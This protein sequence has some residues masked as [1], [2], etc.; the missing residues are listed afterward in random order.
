MSD[1]AGDAARWRSSAAGAAEIQWSEWVERSGSCRTAREAVSECGQRAN[2]NL[3]ESGLEIFEFQVLSFSKRCLDLTPCLLLAPSCFVFR[4]SAFQLSGF[5]LS[6]SFPSA[7]RDESFVSRPDS[8]LCCC[9]YAA[10]N[11]AKNLA[12]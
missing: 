1:M 4:M 5:Q 2:F 12:H 3:S 9:Q 11:P 7:R 8:G 10:I 6:K